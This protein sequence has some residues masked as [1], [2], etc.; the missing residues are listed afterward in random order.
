MHFHFVRCE[1][2]LRYKS[3]LIVVGQSS[4]ENMAVDDKYFLLYEVPALLVHVSLTVFLVWQRCKRR[5]FAASFFSLFL[6]QGVARYVGYAVVSTV[7]RRR[8]FQ[9]TPLPNRTSL[10]KDKL[11]RKFWHS[12]KHFLY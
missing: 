12:F 5:N 2:L 11:S 8:P 10:K 7:F 9:E 1:E 4:E 6:A 3:L